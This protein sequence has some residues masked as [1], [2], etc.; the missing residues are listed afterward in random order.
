MNKNATSP[1]RTLFDFAVLLGLLLLLTGCPQPVE[2]KGLVPLGGREATEL[3]RSLD[4]GS[5]ALDSWT[6]LSPAVERSLAYVNKFPPQEIVLQ[7]EDI[8]V[9]WGAL[10]AGLTRLHS[11]LPLLDEYP[12]LLSRYFTWYKLTPSPLFTGYY[13]PLVEASLEPNPDYPY[14]MYGL[15]DDLKKVDLSRFHPRWEGQ[16]LMYRLEEG[17][18][19]PYYSRLEIDGQQALAGRGLEIAWARDLVDVFFLQIQGS[20][21]LALPDGSRQRIQYAGKNGLRYVSLGRVLVEKGYLPKDG[22]SMQAIRQ[23]LSERPHEMFELLGV[24]PSYVFFTL[25]D[26]GPYGSMG[27][28]V[29][30][31]VSM[32]TDPSVLPLGAILAVDLDLPAKDSVDTVRFAGLGLAQ[33]TGGAIKNHRVDLFCGSGERAAYLAG[34]LQNTGTL[35]LLLPKDM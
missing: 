23:L 12:D 32:A 9:T 31:L 4:P 11:L 5:Q 17:A 26:D 7:G 2:R 18:I 34:H 19:V 14:P 21:R 30:P 10:A 20:G 27:Q 33:D 35:H 1:F 22:V 6:A 28:V 24:N 16:T 3:S 13:E 29:T 25:S 15:P 8:E